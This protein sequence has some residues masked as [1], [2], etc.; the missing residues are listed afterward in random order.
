MGP[1][2][3]LKIVEMAGIGPVPFCS[4]QLAD[5]GAEVLRIDRTADSGLGIGS[6]TK[7]SILHRSRRSVSVDLKKPEGVEVVLKLI[8]QADAL[9]EG[10][11][12]GVMER[13][14]LGPDVCL[15]RNPKLVFGRMTGWG[16]DGPVAHAAGHDINYIALSGVLDSI[17]TKDSGPVPPLNLTGDFGGGSMFL[18]FGVMAALWEAQR[19][20]E[21]QV[22]DVSM[23]E[24]SAYLLSAIYGMN[25]SGYWSKERGTNILDTGSPFY[26]VYETKDGKWVSIGSIEPKFY[27]ELLEKSGLGAMNLPS[28]HDREQWP[29]MKETFAEVFKQKTR[30][31]WCEIMEG[32]DIC[33]A[34]VLSMDEAPKHPQ[35]VARESFIE[36]DGVTQP[37]PAPKFSRTKAEVTRPP[38]SLGEHTEEGLADWGFS[39]DQIAQLRGTGVIV[40]A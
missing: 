4:M 37:A 13:L 31:E 38:S 26:N 10:F 29:Q 17:G 2:Q 32:S 35:N 11:R 7:F 40:Q 12:P 16:Q 21:G 28:Q 1:L 5:M 15:A 6:K 23:A 3:G 27:E 39:R 30:D 25:A 24:G 9:L 18:A 36:L 19:S 22:V 33:F 8:E 20:G 14:G 34:P